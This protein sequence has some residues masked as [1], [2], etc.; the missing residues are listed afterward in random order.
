[1]APDAKI[2]SLKVL[3]ADGSGET[4]DV[5]RALQWVR[6]NAT[7]YNVR[8]VNVSLGHPVFESYED[9]PLAQ[10]VQK[11]IDAGLIVVASAGNY[12][13]VNI[14]GKD[15][16]VYGGIASPGN[17]PDVITVG[18]LNT[19]GTTKRSD[20]VVTTYSSRGPTAIDR[21]IKPDLV[22]PGNK[23]WAALVAGSTVAQTAPPGTIGPNGIAMSGSSVSAGVVTGVVALMLEANPSLRQGHVKMAL[24][25]SAQFMPEGVLAAGS[26]SLNAAGAVWMAV[27][28]PDP[29]VPKAIIEDEEV[30]GSG[31]LFWSGKK[32]GLKDILQGNRIIWGDPII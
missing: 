15:V 10:A 1:M 11:T 8:V 3:K 12:G 31:V 27:K 22:A 25:L 6:E 9:D 5:I 16:P 24:Q 18:A 28:G 19:W 2:V 17:L 14:G 32:S 4:S 23:V 13:K 29:K 26:G 7:R 30:A 21:V 20:D